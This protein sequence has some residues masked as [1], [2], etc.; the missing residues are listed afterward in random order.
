M[1]HLLRLLAVLLVLCGCSAIPAPRDPLELEPLDAPPLALRVSLA[2]IRQ[3]VAVNEGLKG[4]DLGQVLR[5][6]MLQAEVARWLEASGV[7]AGVRAG[8][9][10]TRA[11]ALEDAWRHRDDLLLEITLREVRTQFDGHNGWWLPN[12]FVWWMFMFPAWFVATE[13]YSL[14]LTVELTLRSVDS[15]RVVH[16][17]RR[18]VR[19]GGTFGEFD[20]GWQFFG[21]L[22]PRNKSDNWATIAEK[23]APAARAEVGGTIARGLRSGFFLTARRSR[24]RERTRK[25]TALVVGISRYRDGLNLPPL[26]HAAANASSVAAA[27]RAGLGL[28]RRH[29]TVLLDRKATR[30]SVEAA[31][32][33]LG[34]RAREGDQIVVYFAG[35]GTRGERSEPVLLLSD[36]DR[37]GR[38]RVSLRELSKWLSGIKGDRL[39]LLDCSFDGSG[40]SVA[41][42][43]GPAVKGHRDLAPLR[44]AGAAVLSACSAGD[45]LVTLEQAKG[46]LFALHLAR[47]LRGAADRDHDR[48]VTPGELFALVR[49]HVVAGAAYFA[50]RQR[51]VAV[52]LEH[53]CALRLSSRAERSR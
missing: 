20:R 11:A 23:L 3:I 34:R 42:S 40:R 4:Y 46:S 12:V 38:G 41:A 1:T 7:F 13:E 43:S 2:P 22:Y 16:T 10:A 8:S 35:Y 18:R 25:T 45:D 17:S 29:V 36:A 50:K 9:G 37:G 47:G 51:P 53:P 39:V 32:Q 26:G 48:V 27:L 21:F 33:D 15:G 49:E 19:V 44:A 5:S 6:S 14:V 52:G 31:V 28:E 24:L 30:A